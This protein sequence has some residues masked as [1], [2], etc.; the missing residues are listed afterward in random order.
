MKLTV[1]QEKVS[2]NGHAF[3]FWYS[4]TYVPKQLLIPWKTRNSKAHE[5]KWFYSTCK[6]YYI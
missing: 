5:S 1:N 6:C 2:N 4:Q 3:I